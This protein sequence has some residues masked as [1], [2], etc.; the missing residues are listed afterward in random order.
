MYWITYLLEISKS[1]KY[2]NFTFWIFGN[3]KR[4]FF[5][6][7]HVSFPIYIYTY[8]CIWDYS[9]STLSSQGLFS[10]PSHIYIY[11]CIY[12]YVHIYIYICGYIYIRA[13]IYTCI[14]MHVW[15]SFSLLS[16]IHLSL[17]FLSFISLFL[18]YLYYLNKQEFT[19]ILY[20]STKLT[21]LKQEKKRKWTLIYVFLKI[22]YTFI[23]M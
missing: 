16:L 17:V 19:Y 10:F 18:S 14:Y 12:I 2:W 21:I 11:T 3:S 5:P 15:W 20:T 23:Y 7:R 4:L 13:Y 9:F 6:I 1:I 8:I 22:K